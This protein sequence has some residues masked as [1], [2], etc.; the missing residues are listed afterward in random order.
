MGAEIL[1][2][3]HALVWRHHLLFQLDLGLTPLPAFPELIDVVPEYRFDEYDPAGEPTDDELEREV[4]RAGGF[5]LIGLKSPTAPRS[6][7]AR[8]RASISRAEA[9][10]ARNALRAAGIE[11]YASFR[12]SSSVAARIS[13]SQVRMLRALPVVDYVAADAVGSVESSILHST[14]PLQDTAWGVFKIRAPDVWNGSLGPSTSGQNVHVTI[15]DSGLDAVHLLYGDGP[16]PIGSCLYTI[17]SVDPDQGPHCY[18]NDGHHGAFMGGIIAAENNDQGVIGVAHSLQSFTSIKIC[19][20]G[21]DC[22]PSALMAALD[23]AIQLGHPRHVV[24]I[25]L[26]WCSH[27]SDVRSLLQTA[28]NTGILIVAAAGNAWA[29]VN[30]C[31]SIG[32]LGTTDVKYP[33]RYPEVMAVS[34]VTATDA[35]AWPP[36]VTGGSSPPP[37]PDGCDTEIPA[38]ECPPQEQLDCAKGS[39][40]GPQI[41]I[42]AP[43]F[44][45]SLTSGGTYGSDCGTSGAAAFV[46]GAAALVWSRHLTLTA[47]QVR[48]QLKTY[49][50]NL[51]SAEQ[52]GAGRVD[53]AAAAYPPPPPVFVAITG[54]DV[55]FTPGYYTWN[56]NVSGGTGGYVYAWSWALASTGPFT[57]LKGATSVQMLVDEG[58]A[59]PFWL[60]L[61]VTSGTLVGG[62]MIQVINETS[63]P[64]AP[65]VCLRSP[66]EGTPK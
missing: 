6:S 1:A 3:I 34:G 15:I 64:C 63:N 33:A 24:N 58:T 43:H 28:A 49:A 31:G 61:E 25:S 30:D 7:V 11:P 27:Y 21:N 47:S 22:K 9:L 46:S 38:P 44:A 29:N 65:L 32:N 53:V 40:Y 23:W 19:R 5:V 57:S 12:Y 37:L 39:R 66:D 36:T 10:A 60:R 2:G 45:T 42:S 26:G 56:S 55:I 4:E 48:D 59:S 51:G 50:V 18:A 17:Q 16:V 41:E 20:S 35:F 54:A 8:V 13:A 62:D 14:V 52:F